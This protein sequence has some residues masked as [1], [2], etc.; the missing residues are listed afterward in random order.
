ESQEVGNYDETSIRYKGK[1]I[2][3]PSFRVLQTWAQLDPL[4]DSHSGRAKDEE[5]DD[6]LPDT[7]SSEDMVDKR[8]KGGNIPSKVFKHL[9]KCVGDD[10]PETASPASNKPRA[11][12]H[13]TLK[14]TAPVSDF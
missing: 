10:T 3:S 1:S 9:Q 2:P 13:P 14:A 7:L 6:E 8:Y 12:G 4:P 11:E 5:D